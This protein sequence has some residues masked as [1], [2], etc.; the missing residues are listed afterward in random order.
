[1]AVAPPARSTLS[2]C[3][4]NKLLEIYLDHIACMLVV[5]VRRKVEQQQGKT[6]MRRE[7]KTLLLL[8]NS[9]KSNYFG[10]DIL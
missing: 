6:Y 5:M 10:R 3:D 7:K 1:M 2:W 8:Y 9:H 4:L